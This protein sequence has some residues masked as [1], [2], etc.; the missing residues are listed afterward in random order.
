[1]KEIINKEAHPMF[2]HLYTMFITA[3]F[4][5]TKMWRQPKCPWTDEWINKMWCKHTMEYIQL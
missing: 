1:M 3:L 5:I 2:V 4:T